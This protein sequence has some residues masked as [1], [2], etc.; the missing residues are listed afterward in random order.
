MGYERK[1]IRLDGYNYSVNGVY[2][3]T[4]CTHKRKYLFGDVCN[5]EMRLNREGEIAQ[6]CWKEIP[7]HFNEIDID[8]YGVMPNHVHGILVVGHNDRCAGTK[9]EHRNNHGCSLP[10]RNMALI[11]KIISQ[12]KSSVSRLIKQNTG[13]DTN[14]WQKSYYDQIIGNEKELNHFRQYI[15]DNPA[16][17]QEDEYNIL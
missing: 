10:P 3:V 17:W 4:I 16:D 6:R 8:E 9:N 2:C 15:H 5:G 11:P 14:I 7:N 1:R 12:Y 13:I